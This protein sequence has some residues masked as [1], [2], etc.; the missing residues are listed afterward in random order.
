MRDKARGYLA[1][2]YAINVSVAATRCCCPLTM[3]NAQERVRA[4]A[5]DAFASHEERAAIES[6][7]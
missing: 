1:R 6:A 2:T 3:L 7:S 4:L 5:L